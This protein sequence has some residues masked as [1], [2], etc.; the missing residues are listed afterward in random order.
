MPE[1]SRLVAAPSVVNIGHGTLNTLSDILAD[2]ALSPGSRIVVIA[3]KNS[4]QEVTEQL[5]G[6]VPDAMWVTAE[7]G[8]EEAAKILAAELRS[9]GFDLVIGVG[10][11]RI[12]DIA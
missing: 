4:S 10:G 3:G 12:L 9:T 6:L 1:L 2:P 5:R 7:N 11:G 8:T